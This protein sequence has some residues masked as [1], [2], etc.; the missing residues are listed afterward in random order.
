MNVQAQN[1]MI[2]IEADKIA[3]SQHAP[4]KRLKQSLHCF[5]PS[6]HL[7]LIDITAKAQNLMKQILNS[8]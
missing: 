7:P 4:E 8:Y 1:D 6:Y 3:Q 2:L 5:G